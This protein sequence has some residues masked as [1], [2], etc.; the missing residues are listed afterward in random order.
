MFSSYLRAIFPISF[1]ALGAFAAR[2]PVLDNASGVRVAAVVRARLH[3]NDLHL[4][5]DAGRQLAANNGADANNE[6]LGGQLRGIFSE[7]KARV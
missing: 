7:K 6:R 5:F 1:E 4:E 2:F 3:A